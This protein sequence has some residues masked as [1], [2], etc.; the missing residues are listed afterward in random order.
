[1]AWLGLGQVYEEAGRQREAEECYRQALANRVH[2]AD[3]LTTLARFCQSRGWLAAACTNYAEAIELSPSDPR[4]RLEA[5]Q[6]L[7]ALGR[8]AEAAQRYA[9]AIQLAPDLAQAHFLCGLELGKL[10]K[11]G[12]AEREF[13][14]AA[15]LMP[16]LAEARLNLGIALYHQE[17]LAEALKEFEQVLQRNPTNALALKYSAA[18]RTR[19]ST[20]PVR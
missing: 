4:L 17:K 20:T 3:E 19:T 6:P 16:D 1:L 9:E 14:E 15:R 18:L 11:P 10:E 13:R 12:D 5:G 2:R 8:H 7:A